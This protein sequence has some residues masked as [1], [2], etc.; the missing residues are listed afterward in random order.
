MKNLTFTLTLLLSFSAQAKILCQPTAINTWP[1]NAYVSIEKSI[2]DSYEVSITRP[3]FGAMQAYVYEA[4]LLETD[5]GIFT[6][7]GP[8]ARVVLAPELIR[9]DGKFKANIYSDT[10]GAQNLRCQGKL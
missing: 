9:M 7:N 6:L 8:Q 5:A 2:A 1:N 10:Y 4:T 3:A